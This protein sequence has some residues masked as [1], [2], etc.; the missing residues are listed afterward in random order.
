MREHLICVARRGVLSPTAVTQ[1]RQLELA[2][3]ALARRRQG[4]RAAAARRRLRAPLRAARTR[5]RRSRRLTV[6]SRSRASAG[7]LGRR[8]C[9]R[10]SC[11]T[12]CGA[13]RL[14]RRGCGSA[15]TRQSGRQ[16]SPAGRERDSD[17]AG[18]RTAFRRCLGSR[19]AEAAS[20][21]HAGCLIATVGGRR[22][23]RGGGRA[24]NTLVLASTR[25]KSSRLKLPLGGRIDIVASNR[26]SVS[27]ESPR[28]LAQRKRGDVHRRG[29]W[30]PP[31][32]GRSVHDRSPSSRRPPPGVTLR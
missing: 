26:S 23:P 19:G 25:H 28:R 18:V 4:A 12:R 29:W 7:G 20:A 10:R 14:R 15:W 11:V 31:A 16:P 21:N 24:R 27:Q 8:A 13:H 3:G 1:I 30:L 6:M 9:L 17:R 32:A 5:P 2:E 22:L